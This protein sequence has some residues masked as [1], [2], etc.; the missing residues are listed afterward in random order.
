V[1]ALASDFE[2][3]GLS[4]T[5]SSVK[6]GSFY[7]VLLYVSRYWYVVEVCSRTAAASSLALVMGKDIPIRHKT[8]RLS[9]SAILLVRITILSR[10]YSNLMT[11][12]LNYT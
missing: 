2:T 12:L 1:D 5:T 9:L 10:V 4:D 11:I 8:E 6:S 7:S 3:R